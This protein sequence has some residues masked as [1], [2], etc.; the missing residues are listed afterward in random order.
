[1]IFDDDNLRVGVGR[2]SAVGHLVGAKGVVPTR[3]NATAGP[4]NNDRGPFFISCQQRD[5]MHEK[6]DKCGCGHP[7][8]GWER[9]LQ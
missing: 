1:M 8:D 9:V 5:L 3:G 4:T 7:Q 6:N 2:G